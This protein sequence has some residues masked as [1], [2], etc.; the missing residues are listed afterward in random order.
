MSGPEVTTSA[1]APTGV[2]T[3]KPLSTRDELLA[4][5]DELD[6]Y[7]AVVERVDLIGFE[8]FEVELLLMHEQRRVR[9]L[10]E[11]LTPRPAPIDWSTER[12]ARRDRARG[13]AR[14]HHNVVEAEAARRRREAA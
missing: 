8:P 4:T 12:Y 10:G 11:R 5:W 7:G 13:A 2:R 6:R 14:F 1:C 9:A 3:Q